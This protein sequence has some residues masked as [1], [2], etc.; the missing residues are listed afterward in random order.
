MEKLPTCPRCGAEVPDEANYCT[1]CG[2]NLR[3]TEVDTGPEL[4]PSRVGAMDH[5]RLGFQLASDKP[6]VFA[7]ALLGSL[8]SIIISR[9]TMALL[10]IY[11]WQFWSGWPGP[12]PYQPGETSLL[13]LNGLFALIGFIISYILFFASI[14][15]SRDAYFDAPLDLMGSV[16]YVVRRIGIFIVA[17]IVGAIMSI[18]IILIP[19]VLLM[20]VV[21]VV[22]EAGIGES[23]SRAF[24]VLSRELG[25]ILILI[26]ISIIGSIIL[27]LVPFIGGLLSTGFSVVIGLAFID[28]YYQYKKQRRI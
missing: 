25:D 9:S 26:V 6:M 23:L 14:D 8:I 2:E 16:N 21:M 10:G 11:R 12:P 3:G 7:P 20:F 15:M 28:L 24:S 5:L 18:T 22:D 27:G 1:S 4:R 17:S 13:I 19:A